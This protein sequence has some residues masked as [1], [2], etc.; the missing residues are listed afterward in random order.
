MI[1]VSLLL[2]L[3]VFVAGNLVGCRKERPLGDVIAGRFEAMN[4]HDV[5]ALEKFYADS[6]RGESTGWN[7]VLVGVPAVCRAYERYFH[8]SPDLRYRVERVVEAGSSAVVEYTS[9]G[10]LLENEQGVPE[11]MRGRHYVLRNCTILDFRDGKIVH[12]VTY[13]DQ[14]SFLKQVG[15]FG[16]QPAQP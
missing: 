3:G 11:Y 6:V 14:L 4:R 1:R 13:F 16:E 2:C 12:E 5:T 9:E 8:S 10:T 7:A 15:F